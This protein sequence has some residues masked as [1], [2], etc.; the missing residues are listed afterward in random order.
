MAFNKF[1][2]KIS[3]KLGDEILGEMEKPIQ[4]EQ[5]EEPKKKIKLKGT[6]KEKVSK[7]IVTETEPIVE[8]EPKPKASP[9]A[10]SL[11]DKLSRLGIETESSEPTTKSVDNVLSLFGIQKEYMTDDLL[12]I[13][14]V[15]NIQFDMT[16]PTGLDPIQVSRFCGELENAVSEYV[17]IVKQ[18]DEDVS[19]LSSE[20]SRL[21]KVMQE[22]KERSHLSQFITDNAN[23]TNQL[24]A[25]IV[26]LRAMNENL[27]KENERLQK[28]VK[29]KAMAGTKKGAKE[30]LPKIRISKPVEAMPDISELPVLE[31]EEE[32]NSFDSLFDSLNN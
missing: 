1:K 10:S 3:K 8:P 23:K 15:K 16:A 21:E 5:P 26:D 12:D 6:K 29:N 7:P 9:R 4:V 14:Y 25:T 32:T 22:E 27:K 30:E 19:K 31:K 20:I 17:R 11:E 13:E 2:E 28:E 24:E 18:R